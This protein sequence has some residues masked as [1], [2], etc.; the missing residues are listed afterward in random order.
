MEVD[1]TVEE[2]NQPSVDSDTTAISNGDGGNDEVRAGG[3]DI[4]A[5][6]TSRPP[7]EAGDQG[8]NALRSVPSEQNEN[9]EQQNQVQANEE[10]SNPYHLMQEAQNHNNNTD[11]NQPGNRENEAAPLLHPSFN[12]DIDIDSADQPRQSQ[13]SNRCCSML[14]WLSIF[15]ILFFVGT[16]LFFFPQIPVYNVC[17]DEVAWSEI[18]KKIVT[19]RIDAGLEILTS[20]SNPNRIAAALDEGKGTFSFQGKQFGTYVIPPM[21]VQPMSITDFM[22]IV[23]ITPADRHQAFQLAEAFYH[24]TL[25]LEAEFEGTIRV[26]ALFNLTQDVSAQN[27]TVDIN[28]ISDRSLCHCPTWDGD[29]NHSIDSLLQLME[30]QWSIHFN[31]WNPYR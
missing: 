18:V 5:E 30:D 29:K 10:S 27:I 22:I 20:L 26:P 11:R 15:T 31:Q 16:S 19:F 6:E 4:V 1:A 23:H 9:R 25:I 13:R 3:G 7:E 24:R 12:G 28:E 21:T 2:E 14:H 17:N 8:N